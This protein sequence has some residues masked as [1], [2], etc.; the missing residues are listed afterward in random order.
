MYN[1]I[2]WN[3]VI[4]TVERLEIKYNVVALLEYLKNLTIISFEKIVCQ[5]LK[6]IIHF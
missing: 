5:V 4:E 3:Y 6:K 1:I 2:T